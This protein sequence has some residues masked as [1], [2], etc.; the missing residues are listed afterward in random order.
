MLNKTF[1]RPLIRNKDIKFK[2]NLMFYNEDFYNVIR[3]EHEGSEYTIKI[4]DDLEKCV[5]Y[6]GIFLQDAYNRN[7]QLII[8]DIA[9]RERESFAMLIPTKEKS[10]KKVKI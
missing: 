6:D 3:Y 10:I 7:L 2:C 8:A 9:N 1:T 5:D 4:K